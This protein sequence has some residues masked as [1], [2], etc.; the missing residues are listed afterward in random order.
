MGGTD[1]KFITHCKNSANDQTCTRLCPDKNIPICNRQVYIQQPMYTQ[2]QSS[3]KSYEHTSIF[4]KFTV[5]MFIIL[6]LF[7]VSFAFFMFYC[8]TDCQCNM[9]VYDKDLIKN[10]NLAIFFIGITMCLIA[11]IYSKYHIE[12]GL[13]IYVLLGFFSLGSTVLSWVIFGYMN[14]EKICD[15]DNKNKSNKDEIE[16]IRSKLWNSSLIMACVSSV[17][18]IISLIYIYY[19]RKKSQSSH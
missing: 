1:S 10:F 13:G 5:M 15:P 11:F 17:L 8:L 14:K 6:G 19:D 16:N 9:T 4:S 7:Y 12:V 3:E 18:F 2:S